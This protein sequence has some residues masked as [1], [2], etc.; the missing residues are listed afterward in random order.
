MR[1]F[2][3]PFIVALPLLGTSQIIPPVS[4]DTTALSRDE[5]SS[6]VCLV[7]YVGT[8]NEEFDNT[9]GFEV[10]YHR[11][12]SEFIGLTLPVKIG[13]GRIAGFRERRNVV[14][15]DA[16]LRLRYDPTEKRLPVVPY[17]FA[18]VGYVHESQ[19][20][21]EATPDDDLLQLPVGGGLNV[22]LNEFSF[23]TFQAEYRMAPT[24]DG[25]DNVQFGAG[26]HFNFGVLADS[27]GDGIP[28]VRDKCPNTIGVRDY[29]GCPVPR[30]TVTVYVPRTD[31]L[32]VP[33]VDTIKLVDTIER[34]I[35]IERRDTVYRVLNKILVDVGQRIQF[36][37]NSAEL[38]P[39]SRI[40]LDALAEILRNNPAVRL[41]I[42]GHTSSEGTA[43]RNNE[44]SAA[45]A[46]S[47]RDY[48][49]QP[50][51]GIDAARLRARGYGSSQPLYPDTP[52]QP[53]QRNRRV[54]IT[55]LLE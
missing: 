26:Y 29:E 12:F 10:A 40:A 21:A 41:E 48:L 1:N 22:R 24:L 16:L 6:R 32:L 46:R 50:R 36:N 30:D 13:Q 43:V 27:D 18:G 34:V 51:H 33:R 14:S 42:A 53:D 37:Y 28:N 39:D 35:T 11:N 7:D 25:H 38:T 4:P 5:L 49:T 8:G 19:G 55:R 45:R 9:Y 17:A 31:T 54:E 52:R 23:L 47:V 2:L 15:V 3:L 44:L 20:G